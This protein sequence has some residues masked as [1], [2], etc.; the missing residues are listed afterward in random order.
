MDRILQLP[1]MVAAVDLGSNSFHMV[2][3]QVEADGQ[4][5]VVDK[6]KEMVR[7]AAGLDDH[8]HLSPEVQDRALECLRRFGQRIGDFPP[9]AVRVLGTNTL[10]LARNTDVFL[11]QA[12]A[13]LG[14]PIEIVAGREEARLVYLGVAH[15]V[16]P[17]GQRRLMVD[18]GGGSTELVIG[19][20]FEV[21][22]GESLH[23]GCVS[24]SQVHFPQG[25]INQRRW[26]SA[27]TAARQELRPLVKYYRA[28]GWQCALGA[29][30]TIM[31]VERILRENGWS[32]GGITPEGLNRLR[33][34]LLVAGSVNQLNFKGLGAERAPVFPG[35]VAILSAVFEALGIECMSI[36]SGALR[37]GALYDLLGR[38]RHEDT[39]DRSVGYLATRFQ[40]D[41]LQAERV[42][43]TTL[44]LFNHVAA[45]WY[46]DEG[47]QKILHWAARLHELGLSVAHSGYHKHGA[48]ILANA[49]LAGFSRQE[50]GLLAVLVR[51]HRR[52]F[53]Q[54]LFVELPESM[55]SPGLRLAALLR[56]AVL[57]HRGRG[58]ER[59][60]ISGLE[61]ND[62]AFKL[63]LEPGWRER[64]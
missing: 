33:D 50:Q 21:M 26:F 55:R 22:E 39:R 38:I 41:L 5:R 49:D 32:D 10:R 3:A 46:L 35:G 30:G 47:D 54:R 57:L 48:Y 6:L 15:A 13:A 56:L 1:K 34:A 52:R 11:L 17:T 37:E 58:D 36:A 61:A 27:L 20:G 12:A 45:R 40:I 29:S 64:D 23:M 7:L 24:W 19:E 63:I 4:L 9:R 2:I 8:K 59:V 18:I 14:H 53:H 42:S 62:D 31:I 43:A 60:G 28:L 25:K 16:A 44:E 51:S